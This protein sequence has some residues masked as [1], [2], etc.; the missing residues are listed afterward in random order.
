MI[1]RQLIIIEHKR[2]RDAD[3]DLLNVISKYA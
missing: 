1:T 3:Y 2:F